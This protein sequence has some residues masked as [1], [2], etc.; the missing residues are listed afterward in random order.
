MSS[1]ESGD[2]GQVP[3]SPQEGAGQQQ[4]QQAQPRPSWWQIGRSVLFQI[5]IFYF[6]SSFLR[7]RQQPSQTPDGAPPTAGHN[8]FPRGQKMVGVANCH[9]SSIASHTL[10]GEEGSGHAATIELSLRNMIIKHSG[11]DNGMLTSTKHVT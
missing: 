6:I 2:R 1:Q 10:C 3:A 11:Y 8:L 9:N 7:G 5:M 4:Q